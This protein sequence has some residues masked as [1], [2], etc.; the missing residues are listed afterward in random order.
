VVERE[1]EGAELRLVPA[2]AKAQDQPAATDLVDRGGLLGQHRRVVERRGGD[3]RTQQ[4]ARRDR[5]EAGEDRPCLPGSPGTV[6][7]RPPVEE[8]V[9]VPDGVEAQLLGPQRERTEVRPAGLP[10]DLGE[11]DPDR[12]RPPAILGTREGGHTPITGPHQT[13]AAMIR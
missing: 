9:A 2:G 12:Q 10:L 7:A 8:V 13:D 5:G 3:Q 1:A 6:V 4:Y 11:L